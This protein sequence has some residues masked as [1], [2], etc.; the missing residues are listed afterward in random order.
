MS[1][2][3]IQDYQTGSMFFLRDLAVR[4]AYYW[5]DTDTDADVDTDDMTTIFQN[6][7]GAGGTGKIWSQGDT[8]GDGDVDTAD[9]TTG[10]Q[11][12][13]G[14]GGG[15]QNLTVVPEPSTL[16]LLSMGL[17][18]LAVCAWRRRR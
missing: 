11:E 14:A 10:F 1:G 13:T 15:P 18:G 4:T 3:P 9:T 8:E 5:A 2:N 12:F 16:L 6:F 7:T 17:T